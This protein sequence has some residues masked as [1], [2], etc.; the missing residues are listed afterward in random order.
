MDQNARNARMDVPKTGV[1]VFRKNGLAFEGG[2]TFYKHFV[3]CPKNGETCFPGKSFCR[4]EGVQHF[5][6]V[7]SEVPF[8]TIL[9]LKKHGWRFGSVFAMHG[10][11]SCRRRRRQNHF[12]HHLNRIRPM[13]RDMFHRTVSANGQCCAPWQM[14]PLCK[15]RISLTLVHSFLLKMN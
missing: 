15:E 3:G 9:I 6:N 5:T 11:L 1:L 10:F 7:L 14:Q 8:W 4:F 12:P 2:A 13:I